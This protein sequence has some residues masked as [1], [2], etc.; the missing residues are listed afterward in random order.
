MV[1]DKKSALSRRAFVGKLAT[2][3]A[4]AA[5]AVSVTRTPS[6]AALHH[7]RKASGGSAID[8]PVAPRPTL[9]ESKKDHSEASPP[10]WELL[11][12]LRSGS[13]VVDGW[14][15]KNL[16]GVID[17][18]CVLTLA[19]A[20]GRTNRLHICRNDGSPAGMVYT[21]QLDLVAMNGGR[22]DLP[23]EEGFGQAVAA[24]AH[25]LAAN[26][27][28]ARGVVTTLLSQKQR[29]EQYAATARLR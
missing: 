21:D 14:H 12:P 23:T 19:N 27:N 15:V 7:S 10:P 17:G 18:S 24:V 4:G 3:A 8:E 5:V 13:P 11:Q 29:E 16:S 6:Q 20:R 25:V 26:E 22:G 28:R 2:S 9:E 1:K